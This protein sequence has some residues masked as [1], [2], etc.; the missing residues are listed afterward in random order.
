MRAWLHH[1]A[2]TLGAT[3]AKL[4]RSPL[5][6][7]LNA[8]VIGVALALP[9]GF[10]VA[11]SNLQTYA[12]DLA[13]APQL[14]LFLSRHAEAADVARIDARLRVH[15]GV[16]RYGYVPRDEAL[17]AIRASSGLADVIDSLE[18]NPLPDAFVVD[19]SDGTAKKL[20]AL[21]AEFSKWPAVEHVQLDSLWAQRLEALL[22]LGRLAALVLGTLLAFALVAVTFNTIR[23]QILTQREEIEVARLIG[24]TNPFIRRPFLYFGTLIGLAGGVAAWGIVSAALYFFNDRLAGVSTLYGIA[25]RLDPLSIQDSLSLLVFSAALGWLG[26]RLSVGRHLSEASAGVA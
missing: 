18:R 3:L 20:E 23:L 12:G 25:I 24:A 10:H 7:L 26:A 15:P 21:R 4:A 22:D 6:S 13:A 16:E 5:A 14:S 11:L 8:S 17:R 9:A 19:A 1:H 2:T